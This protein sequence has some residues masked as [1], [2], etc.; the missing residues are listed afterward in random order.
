MAG[1]GAVAL[2][3]LGVDDEVGGAGLVLGSD[4]DDPLGLGGALA[5]REKRAL[6]EGLVTS[7]WGGDRYR[8][9]IASRRW[10][11]MK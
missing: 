5:S 8:R 11:R 9:R 2:V 10:P 4:E 6:S 1:D 3:G 7:A